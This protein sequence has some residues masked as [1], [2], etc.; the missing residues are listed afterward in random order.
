MS[1]AFTTTQKALILSALGDFAVRVRT[2]GT[3]YASVRAEIKREWLLESPGISEPTPDA[4]IDALFQTYTAPGTVVVRDA[5]RSTR[6]D[7]IWS[8]FMWEDAE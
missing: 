7:V 4:A 2:N 1:I 5:G 8:G 3:W 6:R